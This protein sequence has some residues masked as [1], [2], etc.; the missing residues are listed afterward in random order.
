MRIMHMTDWEIRDIERAEHGPILGTGVV[1]EAGRFM[2]VG[3]PEFHAY[4]N[5][6]RAYDRAR[7]A[8]PA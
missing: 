3:S 2:P 6:V 4:A 7:T 1:D 5:R 8:V